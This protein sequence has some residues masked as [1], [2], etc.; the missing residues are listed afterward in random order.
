MDTKEKRKFQHKI[1][2][3]FVELLD[4]AKNNNFY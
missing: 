1:I 4:K 3:K 2:V